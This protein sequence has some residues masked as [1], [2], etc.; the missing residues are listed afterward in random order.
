LQKARLARAF[1]FLGTGRR[2]NPLKL[3]SPFTETRLFV[4]LLPFLN[5]TF[6]G[7]AI[8]PQAACA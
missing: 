6:A 3:A 5:V 7:G 2:D 8:R 1:R 4:L